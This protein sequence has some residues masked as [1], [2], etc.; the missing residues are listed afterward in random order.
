VQLV[1]EE[2]GGR[3]TTYEGGAPA[4]LASFVATNGLLHEEAVSLL[5]ATP[6]V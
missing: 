6:G 4:E 5:G 2:A 1:V 3:C